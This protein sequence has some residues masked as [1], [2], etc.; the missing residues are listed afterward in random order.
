MLYQN[1]VVSLHSPITN[2]MPRQVRKRS[3]TGI[4]HVMLR[5]INRQDIFEDETD[6]QQMT[7]CLRSLTERRDES[8]VLLQ[9]LCTL[10]AYCLMSNHIH[11]LIR[12]RDESVSEIVKKLGK[13]MWPIF[14]GD[15]A[16]FLQMLDDFTKCPNFM[17]LVLI[18][19]QVLFE[20]TR[21]DN[22]HRRATNS[23]KCSMS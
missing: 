10:Y 19:F 3:G 7:A 18:S 5:G 13:S 1:K 15:A 23:S 8:G 4:Y 11:L 2:D 16:M 14:H 20:L 6:Y 21:I 17:W 9:P 22:F 12:E